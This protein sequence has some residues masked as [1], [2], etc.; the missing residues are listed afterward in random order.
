MFRCRAPRP[1]AATAPPHEPALRS[2]A[3]AGWIDAWHHR[4]PDDR[5]GTWPAAAPFRRIDYVWVHP[6]AGWTV[7]S[8]RRTPVSGSDHVGLLATVR[9]PG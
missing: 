8:A 5:G 4:S 1:A 6:G 9:W 3:A 7:A 2:L